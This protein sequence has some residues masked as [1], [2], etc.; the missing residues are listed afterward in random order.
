MEQILILDF[1][2]QYTQ[3]I[4]RRVRELNVYCE[5]HPFHHIPPLTADI[6]GVI[7]S[8]SPCSVRDTEAP[9][10]DLTPFLGKLP[11]LGVC[12]GAQL[13]AFQQ[14]GS[15]EPSKTR[16]YGRARLASHTE[17]PLF[18]GVSEHSQ[19]WMSHGDTI[20]QVPENFTLIART[21][22]V[23]V[24]AYQIDGQHTYGIQ[25]H[26]EVT[27]SLEGKTILKNFVAD[28]CGCA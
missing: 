4:A 25:F 15:V 2:S 21:E 5:S 24:A 6:R 13:M 16:E 10:P 1:G 14:G 20:T 27:H 3:L 26:P 22:T 11:V 18:A 9:N 12:Y 28:I 8:G 7:L 17:S 23:N 19:V